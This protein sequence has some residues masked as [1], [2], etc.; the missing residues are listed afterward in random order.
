MIVTG[1]L[2]APELRD[3]LYVQLQA[4]LTNNPRSSSRS[5]AWELMQ[6]CLTYFTPSDRF[7]VYVLS[8]C[9]CCGEKEPVVLCAFTGL[10]LLR[11]VVLFFLCG[12]VTFRLCSRVCVFF[13][14]IR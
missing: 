8:S 1:S 7:E 11:V 10:V 12:I 13:V 2:L 3:E 14:L 6:E 4:Q 9:Q 5:K